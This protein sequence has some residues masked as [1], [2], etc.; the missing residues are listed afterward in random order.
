MAYKFLNAN[1]Q[2][3]MEGKAN[4]TVLL[5]VNKGGTLILTN[6][7]LI[8]KTA[9]SSKLDEIPLGSILNSADSFNVLIPSGNMIKVCT[10]DGKTHQFL[11]VAKQKEDWKRVL[12]TVVNT[13]KG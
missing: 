11:V 6:Q 2:V 12:T 13:L 4:K 1:E 3:L 5:G 7:R 9:L 10:K 8:F